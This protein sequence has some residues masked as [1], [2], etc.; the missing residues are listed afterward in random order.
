M[1]RT[2]RYVLIAVGVLIV[3][4]LI[5]PFFI[6]VNQFKPTIEERA[7][8]ALGRKVQVG[9]LGFSLFR[10]AV[11]AEDLSIGDDPKFSPSPFLT[12]K[13]L[14]VGV[15]VMPL[16]F[17]KQLKVTDIT[18]DE[19]QVTLLKNKAGDWNYSSIGGSSTQEPRA[20]QKPAANSNPGN[21]SSSPGV[22]VKKLTLKD[23]KIT[24]GTTG[25][26][27][28]TVYDQVNVTASDFS[29][30]SKFPVTV[31]ADLPG[32]GNMK[33]DGNVGPIDKTDSTL[34]PLDAKLHVE[35]LNLATTGFLDPSLGL[36]GIVDVDTTL[37]NQG[38]FAQ[39]NGTIKLAKALL[40]QGGSPA[41]VPLNVQYSTKY[42]LR[43]NSGVLNPSTVKIGNATSKLNGTYASQGETT[44]VD[45]KLNGEGMPAKDLEAFL[46]A[47]GV[48]LPK[49]AS[50]TAGTLSTNL[51]IKGPSDKLVTD[52]TIG[53][54]SAK[55]SGF[56]LGSKMSG[57]S[58][59]TGLKTGKD[60]D[61]E[62][63]TTNIHMAANG[64]RADNFNAV[65]PSLGSMTG[66][67]TLDAKNNLD[68]KMAATLS[69]GAIGAI[70]SAGAGVGTVTGVLGGGK[71]DSCKGGDKTIPFMI[72]GTASDPKFLPDVGGVA[73]GMVKSQLGCAG[74]AVGNVGKPGAVTPENAV[75][76]L[77]GL[78]GKKKKP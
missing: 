34:T 10:G 47:V 31:T 33:L 22:T 25:S 61:I 24:V 16:I 64:L 19:P 5:V 36:G 14:S 2:L 13:S 35:S 43:K 38:G 1:S 39:T 8:T 30:D 74:G 59:M 72:Q 45:L 66:G 48:N 21:A 65:V 18:I 41:G 7:S 52:G 58:A 69:G 42:D 75:Q 76:S 54:Y 57:V 60:L 73:A 77:G 23:G 27:Q 78:L 32:G 71:N 6:P 51:N 44:V 28:R 63:M 56:D 67:G 26:Q 62:K 50:L 55:L 29:F 4:L 9:N 11:T 20:G 53:L 49:G 3:L 70:G 15:E 46:P 68:F 17:S 40:V 12:A 37:A